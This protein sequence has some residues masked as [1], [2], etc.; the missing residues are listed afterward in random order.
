ML[1][2]LALLSA[3]APLFTA[4]D[5][6]AS[7]NDFVEDLR[8]F[9]A[10]RLDRVD[11]Y[12]ASAEYRRQGERASRLYESLKEMLPEEGRMMLLEY[13]EAQA[14]AHYLETMILAERA[15]LDGVRLM[16]KALEDGV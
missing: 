4:R 7:D 10:R 3:S 6:P 15:F 13:S 16:A 12:R 5:A 8:E 9:I 1:Y 14:A 2:E 11:P